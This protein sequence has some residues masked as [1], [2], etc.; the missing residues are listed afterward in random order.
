M[1]QSDKNTAQY[2]NQSISMLKGADR[3]RKRPAVIFG[4]DGLEGC[5]HSF[6]EIL[7]NSVDEAKEGHG[8]EIIITV[9]RDHTI[10][11]EDFGRG[12]PLGYNE[13]E[14]R[15]NWELVFCELYAGGKY[16]N[17]DDNS[18]Y[19]YSLGLNGLGA[20]ATQYSS[21]F[22]E[23]AS[24]DGTEVHT[25]SFKKGSPSSK[26]KSR[27]IEKREKKHGTIIRWRPDLEV[28]TDIAIPYDSFRGVLQQQS[29]A[30]AGLKFILKTENE[31]GKFDTEEFVYENGISDYIRELAGETALTEPTRWH[32][33]TS[34]RDREDKEDYKL[35][36]DIVFCLS[37][38]AS[39]LEY[40][41]NSSFL[42][43]GGSPDKAVR[44]GFVYALDKYLKANGHYKKNESKI[45]FADI[46]DSLILIINSMSTQVSYEN[47][48]KKAITNVFIKDA[49][50]E[51]IKHNLE[52]YFAEHPADA[53]VFAKQVMTNKRA[54]ESAE[55]TRSDIKKKLQATTDF[56][57][58]VEKFVGC[59]S[60][61]PAVRELYIVEGD[62]AMSS[63]KQA[64]NA[65]FQAIIPV[66]GKTLNCLKASTKRIFES[67]I[68]TD[69]LRV[70]GC[71]VEF[72][73]KER[74]DLAMFNY[75]ALRWNKIII[76]TDADEDG[77]QIRTL[78]LTLFYQLLPTLIEKGKVFIAES[79][80]FEITTK[81][82]TY[83]AYNE[84]EKA[85][86]LAKLDAEKIKYKLQRSK[87]LGENEAE[88]MSKTTMNPET[89]R[90][91][92]VTATDAAATDDMFELML[93]DNVA[94]RRQYIA[95]NGAKYIAMADV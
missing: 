28:F 39:R 24:Y 57:N 60:K 88:M 20:C 36:A 15:F 58:R 55:Q 49:L 77:F 51:F 18:A 84:F 3:V 75:D 37:K 74:G 34:G 47:Q 62:S 26:L 94:R 13:K 4:S 10:E 7:S 82:D 22:M 38:T 42:E 16:S 40:Y 5:E 17:N 53:E 52:V 78:L 45:G 67:E 86:I 32:L 46:E 71:G 43:H 65:E 68:I 80:L 25:I 12:V 6:F 29:V 95:D 91:I 92:S 8:S 70:I 33:E 87:G 35:E 41:H 56:S 48:T 69:L 54:R 23:V 76:C 19:S 63:C 79:P 72:K 30:N 93:G 21:E 27:P 9:W 81:N 90:L 31:D 64:R 1:A 83:F 89:R 85:D 61:D 59:R 11:V 2:N 44:L 14:K 50:T 73:G 66:R